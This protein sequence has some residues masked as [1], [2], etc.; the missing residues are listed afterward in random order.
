MRFLTNTFQ[1]PN[2]LEQQLGRNVVPIQT[3]LGSLAFAF[4]CIV[5]A[6][7]AGIKALAT[8]NVTVVASITFI[9]AALMGLIQLAKQKKALRYS[10]PIALIIPLFSILVV[11]KNGYLP[12]TFAF[13]VTVLTLLAYRGRFRLIVPYLFVAAWAIAEHVSP[14]QAAEP[15]VLRLIMMSVVLIYPIHLLLEADEWNQ[16]LFDKAFQSVLV[17]G[18]LVST[19]LFLIN[20]SKGGH[21]TP[22]GHVTGAV[23]FAALYFAISRQWLSA[24]RAKLIFSLTL[25]A[26]YW[27]LV[28]QNGLLPTMFIIGFVLFYFLLLAAFDALML[29][30]ALLVVSL[31]GVYNSPA[32]DFELTPFISRH[33]VASLISMV[34]FYSLIKQREKANS[35]SFSAI[36]KGLPIALGITIGIILLELP[37]FQSIPFDST[38]SEIQLRLMV[39]MFAMFIL[40]TWITSRYWH[41]WRR[42]FLRQRAKRFNRICKPRLRQVQVQ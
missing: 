37:I 19:T 32:I 13:P 12:W 42:M 29:S 4:A 18:M 26:L 41:R 8:T 27:F 1:L 30:V 31:L 36:A 6:Q 15:Y 38:I 25:L 35:L 34:V 28:G 16:A 17:A 3:L 23:V 10:L 40:I 14:V 9:V 5:V 24:A 2:N 22:I 11:Y 20:V 21:G 39:G 7:F 33:V